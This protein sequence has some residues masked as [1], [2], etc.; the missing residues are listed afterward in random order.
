MD[1][2]IKDILCELKYQPKQV[3]SFSY[4]NNPLSISPFCAQE[5][6]S[7]VYLVLPI[8]EEQL[9]EL[10]LDDFS[11]MLAANFRKTDFYS[12]DMDKNTSLLFCVNYTKVNDYLSAAKIKIEDDPYYFKKYV[13]NYTAQGE[14]CFTK[15]KELVQHITYT[16][17]IQ[18]CISD[19]TAF[20]RFKQN[21]ANEPLYSCAVELVTKLPIIPI[22]IQ[23]SQELRSVESYTNE[24]L[25][26]KKITGAIPTLDKIVELLNSAQQ[27]D[28]GSMADAIAQIWSD[29]IEVSKEQT[30]E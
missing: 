16:E 28:L 19:T 3:F 26:A 30:D 17:H 13:F 10:R 12:S 8:G 27:D 6:E 11:P 25:D 1:Y 15:S 2:I 9:I 5:S 18:K 20:N 24:L 4:K 7:Q 21:P 29:Y 22:V 14:E 23:P